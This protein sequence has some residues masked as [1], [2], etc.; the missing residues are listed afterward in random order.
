MQLRD[1]LLNPKKVKSVLTGPNEATH[2]KEYDS[3]QDAMKHAERWCHYPGR[4]VEIRVNNVLWHKF[5][6]NDDRKLFC[7]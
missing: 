2:E 4:R 7:D 6:M 3:L 1:Y 5:W